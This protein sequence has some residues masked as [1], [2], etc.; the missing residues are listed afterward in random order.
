MILDSPTPFTVAL[1]S[2]YQSPFLSPVPSPSL[3]SPCFE[4]ETE[5]YGR[6]GCA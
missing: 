1:L 6:G 5:H 4:A 2:E 3:S